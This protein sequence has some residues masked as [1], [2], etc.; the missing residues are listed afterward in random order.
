[1]C[2]IIL[3]DRDEVYV[4]GHKLSFDRCDV[5]GSTLELFCY[6]VVIPNVGYGIC[7]IGFFNPAVHNN[8]YIVWGVLK[9]MKGLVKVLNMFVNIFRGGR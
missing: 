4:D 5:H 9:L 2:V 3:H 6:V 1:V 7:N 8:S